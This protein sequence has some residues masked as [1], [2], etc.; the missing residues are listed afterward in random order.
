M[1]RGFS[2]PSTMVNQFRDVPKADI[3]RSVFN[4]SR[5]YKTTFDVDY[6]YP[7]FFDEALPGD[8]YNVKMSSVCRLATP[9][10]PL[11]DNLHM[12]FHFFAVANRL[13]WENWQRFMGERE[14]PGD[15]IDYTVPLITPP[16]GTGWLAGSLMDFFGVPVDVDGIEVNA[17]HSRA[18][19]LIF[20]EWFRDQNLIDSPVCDTD[21]GPDDPA[22]YVLLK[23][24]KRADYF[25]SCLPW[26]QKGDAIDLPLGDSAPV[27]TGVTRTWDSGNTTAAKYWNASSGAWPTGALAATFTAAGTLCESTVGAGGVTMSMQPANL[28]ADLSDATAATIN[29]LRQAF[30]LQ[31]ML[32]RDARG[33]TRYVEI[34]RSHFRVESPDARL[35]RPEYLGGGSTKIVI[36]P[37]AQTSES[38]TT[39]QGTLAAVGY[40]QHSGIGFT[41]S[42]VEH[43]V[44]IGLVSVR[45][46]LTYQQGLDKMWSRQTRYDYYWPSL[47]NLGEQEVLTK[48]IYCDGSATD[49]D[50]FGYQERWAELRYGRSLITNQMRSSHATSL[51]AWHLSQ[52]LGAPPSLNQSWI[53]ENVPIDRVVAVPSAPDLIGDFWF[54]VRCVRPLP[55]FSVPGMIDHF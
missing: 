26:P 29:S 10:Y 33:G 51:D 37:V 40:Q 48:E 23:R 38:G 53:E 15:S 30:Q 5:G 21:D 13:L 52:D 9:L 44:I 45:A 39:P 43:S 19:N 25:T 8:T 2:Q 4:R 31:R 54:D 49:D 42:F 3:Q 35:Q 27:V 50:V 24:C 32:E 34:L 55:V 18:Y 46:D 28:Y 11:M 41:K 14:D 6:L 1:T 7:V 16:A 12:D 47:A 20:R 22:D 17:L 36:A